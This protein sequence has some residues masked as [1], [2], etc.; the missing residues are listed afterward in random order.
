MLTR[1]WTRKCMSENIIYRA[2]MTM[3]GENKRSSI[4]SFIQCSKADLTNR[5]KVG[6]VQWGFLL[7]LKS[8]F[9]SSHTGWCYFLLVD[10][11]EEM[12]VGQRTDEHWKTSLF[13]P[14]AHMYEGNPY[15]QNKTE[16]CEAKQVQCSSTNL[17][18]G[19]QKVDGG[20]KHPTTT[21]LLALVHLQELDYSSTG[22]L[23][24]ANTHTHTNVN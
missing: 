4:S 10:Q 15:T 9:L 11:R 23:W 12:Q 22:C 19:G 20:Q 3:S 8:L 24:K 1:C 2:W 13:L 16:L 7:V 14:L 17:P 5:N 18:R 6:W 21:R